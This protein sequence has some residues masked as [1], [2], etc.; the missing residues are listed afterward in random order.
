MKLSFIIIFSL[1]DIFFR[2]YHWLNLNCG[3]DSVKD[4]NPNRSTRKWRQIIK[5]IKTSAPLLSGHG[6]WDT[7]KNENI[8][9]HR[10][11]A[12][13]KIAKKPCKSTKAHKWRKKQ[14][15]LSYTSWWWSKLLWSQNNKIA[16]FFFWCLG[17]HRT[18]VNQQ[19]RTHALN[20]SHNSRNIQPHP[21]QIYNTI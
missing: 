5:S 1:T 17:G 16:K 20:D 12:R 21:F 3:S 18:K 13:I 9:I 14:K 10:T 19:I 15:R 8:C 7:D 6:V 11:R 4:I 2:K